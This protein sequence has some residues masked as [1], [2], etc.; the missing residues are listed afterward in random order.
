MPIHEFPKPLLFPTYIMKANGDRIG[1]PEAVSIDIALAKEVV[2]GYVEVVRP[3]KTPSVIFLC[4]EEGHLQ[5]LP[6]NDH[7]SQLYG[8]PIAGDVIVIPRSDPRHL[9]W[10]T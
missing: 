8:A 5:R 4:N 1:L 9:E 7:A 10:I 6:L 2:G 3:R